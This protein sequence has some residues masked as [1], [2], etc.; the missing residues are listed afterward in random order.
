[1]TG[2]FHLAARLM[3]SRLAFYLVDE[4]ASKEI[5]G[6]DA[7]I[8][9]EIFG[10]AQLKEDIPYAIQVY[11][12]ISGEGDIERL[13]NLEE[14]VKLIARSWTGVCPEPIPMLPNEVTL[15]EFKQSATVQEMLKQGQIPI[16]YDKET[17]KVVGF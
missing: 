1:M 11:L 17:T 6:R 12:P 5:I 10:R 14:E 4:G 2:K 9:Q 13:Y 15:D 7:L 8:Q 16:G 3:A